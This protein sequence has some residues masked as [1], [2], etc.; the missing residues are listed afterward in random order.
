[1]SERLVPPSLRTV[2]TRRSARLIAIAVVAALV[3]CIP[4]GAAGA[5][6]SDSSAV[7]AAAITPP[8]PGAT[9]ETSLLV[10][11]APSTGTATQA[12]IG[13]AVD[14]QG[15]ARLSKSVLEVQVAPGT[16]AQQAARLR[17][18]SDV[19]YVEPNT[20]IHSTAAPDDPGYPSQWPL[21]SAAPGIGAP[22]AWARTTGS[23]GV[24]VGVLDSG[25]D[26]A[27]PDLVANLWTNPGGVGGCAAGTHG[28]N[29][30]DGGCV[31]Q[32]EFGH[33]T[34]VAGIIGASGNNGVGVTGI[35]W[36]TS[37]MPLRVLDDTGSGSIA[38]AVSGIEFAVQAKTK[39]GVNV[40]VLNAS[41][42]D[43]GGQPLPTALRDAIVDANNAGILFVTAAG[44][45]ARDVD[46]SPEYPCS[47][48][49]ANEICVA[50]TTDA[51]A[52]TLA[53][54]SSYGATNVDLAAPGENVAST[55]VDGQ[56]A[57]ASG[58]SMA[59]PEVAGAAALMLAARSMSVSTLKTKLLGSVTP[60]A[61]LSGKV[62]TGGRL[63][64]AAAVTASAVRWCS[65][66]GPEPA[67]SGGLTSAPA[68]ASWAPGR[69]DVFTRNSSGALAHAW[70]G[71]QLV[72]WEN[73]GGGMVGAPAAVSWAPNRIDVFVR[74]TDNQLWHKWYA[75]TWSG[76][77]PLGGV[78]GSGPAAASWGAGRLDVFARGS[79][80][81]LWSRAYT[82][83]GWAAWTPLGGQLGGDPAAVSWGFGRIDV[84]ARG[85]DGQVWQRFMNGGAWA[86]SWVALGGAAVGGTGISS[87]GVGLLDIFV[88]GTN[89]HLFHKWYDA[90]WHGY[91]DLGGN[92]TSGPA[93]ISRSAGRID[94]V[95]RIAGDLLF[96][97]SWQ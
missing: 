43:G 97:F 21:T 19:R 36:A 70:S 46:A 85:T 12:A 27:H 60:I 96:H 29:A 30:I 25:V 11:V 63:D 68:I 64:L 28:L 79:D 81:Q 4:I 62:A 22:S 3:P 2:R 91:E 55:W 69:L 9:P 34:H 37:L 6:E 52:D 15:V 7:T 95:S 1:M 5:T 65:C 58:T 39:W 77:E 87:R 32:D 53:S 88:T 20:A 93:A 10:G 47:L 38:T 59:T 31:P 54:F 75:G 23:R 89:G 66:D 48:R 42:G 40:R 61:A 80:G 56:Y 44:N 72:G 16:T 86:G 78:L 67:L 83:T 13:D 71:A 33:G 76:W 50:A 74:G 18:R 57:F 45:D 24:V 35:N 82:G 8:V 14:A 94:V 17:S 73:L 90:G 26:L 49:L 51:P 41:W 92:L 84:V